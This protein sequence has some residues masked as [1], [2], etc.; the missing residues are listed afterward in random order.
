M[1]TAAQIN[2]PLIGEHKFVPST[3]T[4][5]TNS[6]LAAELFKACGW[7]VKLVKPKKK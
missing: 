7:K 4:A 6:E 1:K 2:A 5:F 3:N